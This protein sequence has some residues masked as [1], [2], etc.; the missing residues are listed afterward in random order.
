MLETAA[1]M[2]SLNPI[3]RTLRFQKFRQNQHDIQADVHTQNYDVKFVNIVSHH[4]YA[5]LFCHLG[6]TIVN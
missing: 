6:K 5:G 3:Y 2:Q 4:R 1:S